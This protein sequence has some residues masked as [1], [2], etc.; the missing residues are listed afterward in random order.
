MKEDAVPLHLVTYPFDNDCATKELTTESCM[1]EEPWKSGSMPR[2]L[3][4]DNV[5]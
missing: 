5:K 4:L 2:S 1:F 3:F